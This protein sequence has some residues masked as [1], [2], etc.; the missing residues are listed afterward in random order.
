MLEPS[1]AE[2]KIAAFLKSVLAATHLDLD[3]TIQLHPSAVPDLTIEFT[4]PDTR[5][6]TARNAELLRAI[7]HLT[8]EVRGLEERPARSSLLRCR[9][10][11]KKPR[12]GALEP[13]P[14][15]PHLVFERPASPLHSRPCRPTSAASFI[16]SAPRWI[17]KPAPPAKAPNAESSSPCL[18]RFLCLPEP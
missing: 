16:S 14:K 6:L 7:E 13:L 4:G 10:L 8:A 11:Q 15:K 5:Y 18:P 2:L 3:F 9:P 17:S 1:V 12:C